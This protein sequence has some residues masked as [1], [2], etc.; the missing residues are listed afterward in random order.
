MFL[1]PR[2]AGGVDSKDSRMKGLLISRTSSA[3]EG[4][5]KNGVC[6]IMLRQIKILRRT[7][8]RPRNS[9]N[10]VY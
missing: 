10:L 8:P 2:L 4:K 6:C 9:S 1:L 3:F 7:S 5:R